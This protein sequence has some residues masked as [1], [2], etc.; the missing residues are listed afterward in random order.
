MTTLASNLRAARGRSSLTQFQLAEAAGVDTS[1]VW[2]IESGRTA[3]PQAATLAKLA[4]VL[5]VTIE[6]LEGTTDET[7]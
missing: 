7:K 2:L 1:A 5:G 6:S 3:R 4:D